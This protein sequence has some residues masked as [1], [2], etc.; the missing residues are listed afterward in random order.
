MKGRIEA[1]RQKE[2]QRKEKKGDVAGEGERRDEEKNGGWKRGGKPDRKQ[3]TDLEKRL[4]ERKAR[5]GRIEARGQKGSQREGIVVRCYRR[6]GERWREERRRESIKKVAAKDEV[7]K[8]ELMQVGI[9][10]V[11]KESRCKKYRRKTRRRYT[12]TLKKL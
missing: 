6:R 7:E 11:G 10:A 1:G 9:Q 8:E 2:S 5:K 4:E 3:K 12:K